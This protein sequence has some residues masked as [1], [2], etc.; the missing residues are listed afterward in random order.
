MKYNAKA[1][2]SAAEM[3]SAHPE[4][5]VVAICSPNGLHAEHSIAALRAGFHVLCEKPMAL[6]V[7]DCGEKYD[8][9]SSKRNR[10]TFRTLPG[11]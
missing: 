7:Q 11:V 2:T 4:I 8:N 10:Y 6:T 1:Y 9:G 5:V 3:L